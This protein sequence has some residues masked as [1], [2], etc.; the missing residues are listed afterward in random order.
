MARQ[1]GIKVVYSEKQ[2]L[3]SVLRWL[4]WFLKAKKHAVHLL[5]EQLYSFGASGYHL[6]SAF[7]PLGLDIMMSDKQLSTT[8]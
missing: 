4:K 6:N 8:R 5:S 1:I 3:E 2:T 7:S